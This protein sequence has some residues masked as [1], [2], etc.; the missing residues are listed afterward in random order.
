MRP[1]AGLSSGYD[2]VMRLIVPIAVVLAV[3][4]LSVALERKE[5]PAELTVSYTDIK[6]A[7]GQ[8]MQASEDIR[9]GYALYEGLLS[10]NPYTFKVIPGVAERWE[11][12]EDQSTYT[13]HLRKDAKWSDGTPVTAEDFTYSWRIGMMPDTGTKYVDFLLKIRGAKLF[14]DWCA[15]ELHGIGRL[16]ESERF[17]AG[18][19]RV[20]DSKVKFNELVG[21]KATDAH[22][23]VVQT[24]GFIPYFE[25]IMACWPLW[26]LPRHILEDPR[27]MLDGR[28]VSFVDPTS[29][30]YRR[31]QQWTKA[32]NDPP[33]MVTNG[34]Y[35]LAYWRF[36][37]DILLEANEHYWNH[38]QVGTKTLRLVSCKDLKTN[39]DT[40]LSGAVS[41]MFNAQGLGFAPDLIEAQR[42][43]LRNDVNE[44][45]SY[46]IY[47]FAYN[48]RPRLPD[49]SANP[50]ADKRVR[51]AFSMV[52]DK[53]VIVE[54]VTRM[55]Q[56]VAATM[57]KEGWIEGYTPPKG[58][59]C[60]SDAP[61]ESA[62]RAMIARARQLL[63]EA[64]YPDG[65][66]FPATN[67]LINSGAGH[68]QVAQALRNMWEQ[69]LGVPISYDGQEWKVMLT[70]RSDGE[71][72]IARSGWYGDYMDPT[73]FLEL[74]QTGNGNNDAGFSD[75]YYDGLLEKASRTLDKAERMKLLAEA[76]R[77]IMD[78]QVPA[79]P[80]YFYKT[81]HLYNPDTLGGVSNH[82]RDIQMFYLMRPKGG[83]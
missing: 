27:I 7:D 45:D 23:L 83:E 61:D 30:M 64:G 57:I 70:R 71:F 78:E 48:T 42:K 44:S 29:F 55:R 77:Y 12:S 69:H 8:M 67:I 6:T 62:R 22:T 26:P 25:E 37:R 56:S 51:Q 43:G 41:L 74:F 79:L 46:G 66:G 58:L 35:R 13:F 19:R 9:F 10:F 17:A 2:V 1:I 49:G 31:N 34:P 4:G 28:P 36:K 75:P 59:P 60:L 76:E 32:E 82:P 54:K 40:Y 21:V 5:I 39:F 80:L 38:A 73:T 3:M 81:V 11:I 53:K 47:Y 63:S 68:E 15:A 24:E 52:I 72:M 14:A 18:R 33:T 65:R 20:E 16:P 50:F